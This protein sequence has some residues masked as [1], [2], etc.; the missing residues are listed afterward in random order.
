MPDGDLHHDVSEQHA[1]GTNEDQSTQNHDTTLKLQIT[2]VSTVM[3]DQ[4]LRTKRICKS[5]G[6]GT[7]EKFGHH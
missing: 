2:Q 5:R 1:G 4:P 6:Y 7:H 3:L